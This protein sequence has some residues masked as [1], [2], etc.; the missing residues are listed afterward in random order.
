MESQSNEIITAQGRL[1]LE[2]ELEN[3]VAVIRPGLSRRIYQAKKF[4]GLPEGGEFDDAKNELGFVEGRIEYRHNVLTHAKIVDAHDPS[5]VSPRGFAEVSDTDEK[6][7]VLNIVGPAEVEPI[8]GKISN[9]SPVAQA[10]LGKRPGDK[11]HVQ[12][13]AG[14]I[15]FLIKK[16]W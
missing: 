3:L 8:R 12:A 7:Q 11:V 14:A 5:V 2:A 9:Q 15:K 1:H 16:V 10:L 4:G 6:R 13:P